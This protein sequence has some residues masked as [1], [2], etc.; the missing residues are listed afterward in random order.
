[1]TYTRFKVRPACGT[2]SGYDYHRRVLLENPCEPCQEA[3]RQYHRDRR[4]RDKA[5][6]NLNSRLWRAAHPEVKRAKFTMEEIT[7]LYGTDCYHCNEPIDFE[8]PRATGAPG[9]EKS[10]HPDHLVPLS[11]GGLDILD[12]IRP[13]HAQCN[14]RKWATVK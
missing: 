5:K 9:W 13:S 12:N 2:R 14:V 8:A 10:Y 11:K 1:M 3:E 6:I 4:V 7:G